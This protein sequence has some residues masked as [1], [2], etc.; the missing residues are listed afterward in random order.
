MPAAIA[1]PAKR[2]EHIA[3]THDGEPSTEGAPPDVPGPAGARTEL[4]VPPERMRAW[5]T[6]SS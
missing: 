6:P 2:I 5:G 3:A 1:E 4:S